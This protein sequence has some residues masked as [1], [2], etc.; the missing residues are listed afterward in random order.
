VIRNVVLIIS[1]VTMTI[2]CSFTPQHN[3]VNRNSP[4]LDKLISYETN[5]PIKDRDKSEYEIIR[6]EA[7]LEL[8]QR[9]ELELKSG[10][11]FEALKLM[12][13][14]KKYASYHGQVKDVYTLSV[15]AALNSV[16]KLS[17]ANIPCSLL[18]EK[19]AFLQSITPDSIGQLS[20][21]V[22]K[23]N[24]KFTQQ[25]DTDIWSN[26]IFDLT[27]IQKLINMKVPQ[28]QKTDADIDPQLADVL[29]KAKEFPLDKMLLIDLKFLSGIIFKLSTITIDPDPESETEIDVLAHYNL[30]FVDESEGNICQQYSNLLDNSNYS[31]KIDCTDFQPGWLTEKKTPNV[32]H[33]TTIPIHVS[34][35]FYK[36]IKQLP[37]TDAFT[38]YAKITLGYKSGKQKIISEQVES[39][40]WNQVKK[41]LAF[42]FSFLQNRESWLNAD[43]LAYQ[44]PIVFS[45]VA[46]A[47]TQFQFVYNDKNTLKTIGIKAQEESPWKISTLFPVNKGYILR[48]R[49][50]RND[51]IDLSTV[52]LSFD[53]QRMIEAITSTISD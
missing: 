31:T 7:V 16:L 40:D 3:I 2:S 17:E 39:V 32:D 21:V 18:E 41:G 13:I 42:K 35:L 5:N 28:M 23:C 50:S 1:I 9:S 27:S 49:L 19:V 11:S 10:N 25:G 47:N 6:F 36:R 15:K 30:E 45:S 4:A 12:T 20:P 29:S 26:H 53:L 37:V 34:K 38:S 14:A 51:V 52:A 22:E 43:T 44:N 46:N 33:S 48:I 24:I 8:L